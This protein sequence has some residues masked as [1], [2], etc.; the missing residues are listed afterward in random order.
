MYKDH[1]RLSAF[2]Q[3]SPGKKVLSDGTELLKSTFYENSKAN[4][5]FLPIQYSIEYLDVMAMFHVNIKTG[6]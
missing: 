6:I 1:S 2:L 4:E 5:F 3:G